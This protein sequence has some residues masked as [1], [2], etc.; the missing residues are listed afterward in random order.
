[1]QLST[2][3]KACLRALITSETF[4]ATRRSSGYFLVEQYLSS[5]PALRSVIV[6]SVFLLVV[7]SGFVAAYPSHNAIVL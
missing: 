1:M 3:M 7:Q 5:H 4:A 6:V 2:G